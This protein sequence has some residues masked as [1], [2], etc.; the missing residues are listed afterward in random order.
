MKS[1]GEAITIGK[2]AGIPVQISHHKAATKSFWGK[3]EETL[4]LLEETR[5]ESVDITVDQYPYKA[6]STSL[7]TCLPPWAHEGGMERL[8]ERLKDPELRKRIQSD[9][10]G[11]LLGWEN[12]AGELGWENVYVTSVKTDE[13]KP[14]EGKNLLEIQEHRGDTDPYT[15]LF[16]LILEEEGAAGMIIFAM[17]EGDVRRIMRHPL[18]MVGTDSGASSTTGFMRRGKPHPRGYG[19]YP[20]ILGKYVRDYG[21]LTLEEAIRKMTSFPAQRFGLQTRG[22]LRPGIQADI[23]VLN[24]ETV[25]DTATYQEPHQLPKGI[26]HVIVNGKITVDASKPL[27]TL[28]GR[29]LRRG[30]NQ[31]RR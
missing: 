23:V 11:G 6:G 10:I 15:S 22:V 2:E 8:L 13:N 18:Q 1:L 3:S 14:V 30:R 28:S 29:T 31:S 26:E 16:D 7:V 25:I 20:K 4:A 5:L 17:D 12:F 19:S 27:G 24:P 9:I 21:I